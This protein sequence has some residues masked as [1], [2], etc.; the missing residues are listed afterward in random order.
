VIKEIAIISG[1]GGTGKT[2]M[3]GSLAYL[4]DNKIVVDC[5]VDAADLHLILRG[6][7]KSSNNF[8][9]SQKAIIDSDNCISCGICSEYCRF[10]AIKTKTDFSVNG[11]RFYVDKLSC[12]GCGVCTK[13]CPEKAIKM[14][15]HIS[16]RWYINKTKYG[17]LVH[18]KLGIAEANSGRLVSLLRKTA[19]DIAEKKNYEMLLI[20]GSPGIGC[21][22]IASLT[23]VDYA[24][25]VTEP[26]VSA[27]HDMERLF[28]LTKHFGIKCGICIN[29]FDINL[30]LS[31]QIEKFSKSNKIKILSRI[32]YDENVTKAQIK[33]IPYLE[34]CQDG[35]ANEFHEL[36][37]N[38]NRELRLQRIK[39]DKINNNLLQISE[40]HLSKGHE[41]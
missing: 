15:D 6:K 20:D 37:N 2:S 40:T 9:G 27:I 21:P 35:C 25:I 38:I 11:T 34:Y 33:G 31:D 22:V 1:K 18:A 24:L 13:F 29:K 8:I 3:V 28:D 36:W 10:D 23:G 5:D 32:P 4:A 16:G 26:T 7:T 14:E 12:E 30:H 39:S 17:P 19:R 41:I